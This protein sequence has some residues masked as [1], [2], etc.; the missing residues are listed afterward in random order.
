[1]AI[2]RKKKGR[3]PAGVATHIVDN[4]LD[5][6]TGHESKRLF[7]VKVHGRIKRRRHRD[8]F[9]LDLGDEKDRKRANIIRKNM[10]KK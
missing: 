7:S 5:T 4:I 8:I 6:N 3:K 10:R 2:M 9:R 1:M